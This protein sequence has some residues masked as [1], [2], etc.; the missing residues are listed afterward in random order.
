[1]DSIE[2]RVKLGATSILSALQVVPV[3]DWRGSVENDANIKIVAEALQAERDEGY[4]VGQSDMKEENRRLKEE[5]QDLRDEIEE[6]LSEAVHLL[7]R[8]AFSSTS[9][10]KKHSAKE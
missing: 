2:E 6:E 10:I 8:P 7:R 1:M 5:L 4:K 9:F 3:T